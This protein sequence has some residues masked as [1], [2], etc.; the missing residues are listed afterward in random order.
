[1]KIQADM[2][3]VNEKLFARANPHTFEITAVELR[4]VDK[5]KDLVIFM[6][7]LIDKEVYGMS[8][9]KS[10]KNK[11]IEKYGNDTDNWIGKKITIA[12]ITQ[13]EDGKKIKEIS[14]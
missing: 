3:W 14:C 12:Q 1:M 8:I 5:G 4:D 6:K 10:N 9:W 7:S 2:S 13:P 11:L